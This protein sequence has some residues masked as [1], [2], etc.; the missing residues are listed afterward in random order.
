MLLLK[1]VLKAILVSSWEGLGRVWGGFGEGLGRGWR[2]LGRSWTVFRWHFFALVCGIA[3]KRALGVDFGPLGPGFGRGL[4]GFWGGFARFCNGFSLLFFAFC[5]APLLCS[6][7]L[8]LALLFAF[9]ALCLSLFA[10]WPSRSE[11]RSCAFRS[12]LATT[13]IYL[14]GR[15]IH[16]SMEPSFQRRR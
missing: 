9:F 8:V 12:W 7:A 13:S 16:L 3:S 6:F 14:V 2:L 11:S 4:G 1:T 15:R 5:F 10:F